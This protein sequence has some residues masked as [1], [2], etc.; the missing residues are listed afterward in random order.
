MERTA[1]SEGICSPLK[2]PCRHSSKTHYPH[3]SPPLTFKRARIA[4]ITRSNFHQ[5]PFL[6]VSLH[7]HA[8]THTHTHT[9]KQTLPL[10]NTHTNRHPLFLLLTPTHTHTQK[11]RERDIN[12]R[13]QRLRQKRGLASSL[14]MLVD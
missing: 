9:H 11:E 7:T 4:G 12:K 13:T 8:H 5:A 1:V 3:L 14:F 10:S 2:P 6:K